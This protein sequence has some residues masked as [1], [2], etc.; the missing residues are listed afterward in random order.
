[1]NS[2]PNLG[3][4]VVNTKS[5]AENVRSKQNPEKITSPK[6]NGPTKRPAEKEEGKEEYKIA[7]SGKDSTPAGHTPQIRTS[8]VAGSP[9]NPKEAKSQLKEMTSQSKKKVFGGNCPDCGQKFEYRD[10]LITHK[11]ASKNYFCKVPDC[12]EKEKIRCSH[13]SLKQHHDSKHAGIP[14]DFKGKYACNYPGCDKTFTRER[15]L[16]DHGPFHTGAF[17]CDAC[18]RTLSNKREYEAHVRKRDHYTCQE[19]ECRTKADGERKFCTEKGLVDHTKTVHNK[20]FVKLP[21][22]YKC[23]YPECNK[24]YIYKSKLLDHKR[25]KGHSTQT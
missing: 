23:D 21:G 6:L 25:M 19:D 15:L 18:D 8:E 9:S 3:R 13:K 2:A 4:A 17:K 14:F 20:V 16:I 5:K 1:M 24:S 11:K 12:P 22:T 7:K 10:R